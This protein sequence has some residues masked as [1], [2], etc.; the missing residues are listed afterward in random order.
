MSA[1]KT[2]K[3]KFLVF[4]IGLTLLTLHFTLA[5]AF[6]QRVSSADLI[7]NIREYDGK[8]II[9]A[10]EVIGDIMV[11]G[12]HAWVNVH[13]GQQAV[14]IWLPKKMT[15]AI[16]YTGSYKEIG[17]WVEI[18]GTF[19]QICK[20]HGGEFDIH[21]TRLK[22]VHDGYFIPRLFNQ[23]RMKKAMVLLAVLG[24]IW[25]LRQLIKT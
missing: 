10:G 6:A 5:Y 18:T 24:C 22:R 9:Y 2:Q 16:L 7:G 11:R 14:G 23:G 1:P 19:H 12:E 13:D 20:E 3:L 4:C 17:D 15:E 21:A 25:I 8:T